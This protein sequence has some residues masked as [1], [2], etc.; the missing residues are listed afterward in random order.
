MKTIFSAVMFLL[1]LVPAMAW[2]RAEIQKTLDQSSVSLNETCSGTALSDTMILTAAHCVAEQY[3]DVE[4]KKVDDKGVVK[5]ETVRIS[6]PGHILKIKYTGG[7]ESSRTQIFYK[8]VASEKATD[9]ALVKTAEPVGKG[10]PVSCT[11]PMLLDRVYAIGNPLGVLFNT[12]TTGRVSSLNR[13]YR[14]IGITNYDDPTDDGEHTFIQHT[15]P[16]APGSSGGGLF[17]DQGQLVGVNVRGTPVGS[18]F[19]SVH[20]SDIKQFLNNNSVKVCNG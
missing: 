9:L 19:L 16:I 5:K 7:V 14:D 10:V 20:T 1:S 12:V 17:N 2:D 3:R 13:S 18:V 8:I 11:P 6:V 4:R 15:A